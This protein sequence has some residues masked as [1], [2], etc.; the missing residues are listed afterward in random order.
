MFILLGEINICTDYL[1]VSAY[2]DAAGESILTSKNVIT[3]KS[4]Q[5]QAESKC[6]E[7][8]IFIFLI[9]FSK[10]QQQNICVLNFQFVPPVQFEFSNQL[11]INQGI[12]DCDHETKCFRWVWCLFQALLLI[13][14]TVT[15]LFASLW[16][17]LQLTALGSTLNQI[18]SEMSFPAKWLIQT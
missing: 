4:I 2:Y 17:R 15:F 7:I 12:A 8:L 5:S 3:L 18:R 6:H 10:P 9:C 16:W 11:K 14:P 1:V 13:E